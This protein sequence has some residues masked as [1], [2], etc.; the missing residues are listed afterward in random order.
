MVGIRVRESRYDASMAKTTAM[1]RGVKRYLA[2]P[3]SSRTG[4]NTMQMESVETKAGRGDLLRA[5]EHRAHQRLLHGHV[6]VRVFDFHRGVVHQDA[7]RQRQAA[8][9]HDVDGLA[10]Q[11][12]NDERDQDRKRNGDADDDGAAPASE[13]EQ[14]HQ[15]GEEGGGDGFADHAVD[16]G[17]HEEGLIEQLRGLAVRAAGRREFWAALP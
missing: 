12:E 15:A 17:A 5:I 13:E 8:Q 6:A 1:A 11:A 16:G 4:T 10:H 14:D 2:A 7:D 3:V 9:R